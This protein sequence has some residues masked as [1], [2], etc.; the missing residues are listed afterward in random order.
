[1]SAD[2]VTPITDASEKPQRRTRARRP[3]GE[4]IFRMPSR[5]RLVQA[6]HGVCQAAEDIAFESNSDNDTRARLAT[7]S[8]ILAQ[9]LDEHLTNTDS[10]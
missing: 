6:L 5:L 3:K 8:A 7:A 10:L 4:D 1:M 2:N 9:M